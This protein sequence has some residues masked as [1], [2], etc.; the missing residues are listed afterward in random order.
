MSELIPSSG[1]SPSLLAPFRNGEN[2]AIPVRIRQFAEQPPVRRALP[3]FGG[4]AAIGLTALAWSA[5]MPGTQRLLY[6]ALDDAERANVVASLDKA[7]IGYTIDPSSGALSVDENDLYKARMLV[8]S[9]G[10][11][12]APET[13]TEMLVDN[14]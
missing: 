9:D 3:W 8:A 5:F 11:L 1:T 7:A 2:A 12:A 6:S 13:G 4:V 10:A 14:A